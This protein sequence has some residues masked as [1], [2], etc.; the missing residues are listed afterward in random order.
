[1]KDNKKSHGLGG[2]FGASSNVDSTFLATV[3]SILEKNDVPQLMSL[4]E[5]ASLSKLLSNWSYFASINDHSQFIDLSVKL[6]KITNLFLQDSFALVRPQIIEFYKEILQK[7]VKVIYRALNNNKPSLT[8]PNLR[9][10]SNIVKF[11]GSI[12]HEFLNS[13]DF[14][15]SILPNLLV[16]TKTELENKTTK[17]HLSIR[18]NFI[19]FWLTLAASVPHYHRSD[20]MTNNHKIVNNLWKFLYI[21]SAS[22]IKFIVEFL[23]L[24]ILQEV[25]FKRAMKCKILNENFMYKIQSVFSTF[26]SESWFIEFLEKLATDSKSGLVYPHDSLFTGSNTGVPVH[27]N[28]KTF[29]I[30]NKVIYTL[31]TTLK[32]AESHPELSF[33]VKILE[34]NQ[35]L[36]APYM[37]WMVQH[38]GGYHDP[39]LTSWW[40]AHTLLYSNILQLPLPHDIFSTHDASKINIRLVSENIALAPLNKAALQKCLES[41]TKPII[42]QFALQ[43]IMYTIQRLESFL[44][45]L[46]S[47]NQELIEL[48][49]ANLPDIHVIVQV[50]NKVEN[51]SKL[52][53]LTSTM[54]INKYESLYPRQINAGS[55][56]IASMGI[57]SIINKDLSTCSGYDLTLLDLYL[58][59]QSNQQQEQELKW[60]NKGNGSNSLFTSLI[61]LSS[62]SVG[63]SSGKTFSLLEKLTSDKL[64]FS[65][66]LIV[67]PLLALIQS[68]SS[69]IVVDDAVWNLLDEVVSRTVRTPYKYLDLS[70]EKYQDTSL[71]VV[72]LF[73]QFKFMLKQPNLLQNSRWFF[74]LLKFLIVVGESKECLMLLLQDYLLPDI[75]FNTLVDENRLKDILEFTTNNEDKSTFFSY[76][77][78][79][80]SEDLQASINTF[81]KMIPTS[82][83]DFAAM[84]NRLHLAVT[85]STVK[86]VSS[87][88]IELVS[89]V[90]NYLLSTNNSHLIR[91]LES[92]RFWKPLLLQTIDEKLSDSKLLF[93]GLFSEVLQQI[94]NSEVH[95]QELNQFIF[96]LFVETR[97]LSEENQIYL[98]RFS[99]I[100]SD[101]QVKSLLADFGQN[102]LLILTIGQ[103]CIKRSIH[104]SSKY[105]TTLRNLTL[106]NKTSI[107]QSLVQLNLVHFE[108]SELYEEIDSIVA[109]EIDHFLLKSFINSKD[110]RAQSITTYL[111][112]KAEIKDGSLL[113]FI[114]YSVSLSSQSDDNIDA[115]FKKVTSIAAH[116][117]EGGDFEEKTEW[118]QL[119]AIFSKGV[120]FLSSDER[121]KLLVTIFSYIET[122]GYKNSF[123]SEF[124]SLI[125]ACVSHADD[126]IESIAEWIHKSMLYITKKFAESTELSVKFDSFL[127]ELQ[128]IVQKL[129]EISLSI[130]KIV[131]IAIMNTQLEV[132][133]RHPRWISEER[134]LAY[135]NVVIL[136]ASKNIIDYEKLLQIFLNNESSCLNSLP[137][138]SNSK[139]RYMSALVLYNLF[140]VDTS[141]NATFSLL[142]R[143]VLLYLGSTRAEDLLLKAILVKIESHISKSWMVKVSN[144]EF[145]EEMTNNDIELV[146]EDRLIIKSKSDFIVSLSKNF[147]KNSIQNQTPVKILPDVSKVGVA[148]KWEQYQDFYISIEA[149]VD[150]VYSATI[151]D[152]EFLMMLIINN[153][154]LVKFQRADGDEESVGAKFDIKK[155]IDSYILQFIVVQL[156]NP[157]VKNISQI[158]LLG[159]LKSLEETENFKDKSI[160]KVYISNILNTLRVSM[161]HKIPSLIWYIYSSFIPIL[162]NPGH[163]LY[164]KAFRY[165]LGNP[166]LKRGDIPLY[167]GIIL[168]KTDDSE[169]END[170][171]YYKQVLWMIERLIEGT[172]SKDDLDLIK[173]RGVVE[174]IMNLTNSPY[175]TMKI[176]TSIFKYLSVLQGLDQGSDMLITRFGILTSL[177]QISSQLSKAGEK[178]V[179][180]LD[181]QLKIN[182]EQLVLRFGITVGSSKRIREWTA[183]DL[184]SYAKRIHT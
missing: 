85:N 35:E 61:K 1:M 40:V 33:V 50:N 158:L 129:S 84:I 48:V 51:D 99:W 2:S 116:L 8:N 178:N 67:S 179:K 41:S 59:I 80:S 169:T 34:V 46:E 115:F 52:I 114:A 4:L 28:N 150:P 54:I 27:I 87:L 38:G 161:E 20:L 136:T 75:S 88:I 55:A 137:N 12:S 182:I 168:S 109:S 170:E 19:R 72:A 141:K 10:L 171:S 5:S 69:E 93:G 140:Y 66:E 98:S 124:A 24:R 23:D 30:N 7:H 92:P 78:N 43:L 175:L 21:D 159:I 164:E 122:N 142:E 172:N 32:P 103:E 22:T 131:P 107:L 3:S 149:T 31:L 126:I 145:S 64:L 152:A 112:N 160:Y 53:K 106:S 68:F 18:F 105:F 183:D 118:N 111:I 36:V 125:L 173:F 65:T 151:Y 42:V 148:R 29:K 97:I 130:W 96:N 134:Y 123:I 176:K 156:G 128:K 154:E 101:A 37:N 155:L 47:S 166:T 143:I 58:S 57:S 162:S 108:D 13:F 95:N 76:I 102:G 79:N 73:E 146:G 180:L 15:L 138:S 44:S 91:Y 184:S 71:F 133:L 104:I 127:S 132:L 177:E 144:W 49:F 77:I 56:K 90:G 120:K 63:Q 163:F 117:L 74:D 17:E 100:L 110:S 9:I 86:N 135:A 119:L 167:S 39:S 147:I 45:V 121:S 82:S 25:N 113:C 60:W 26:E 16:P 139:S 94:P 14:T 165:V 11:D 6:S 89:K 181:E 81:E 83:L 70:H 174:W 157:I 62:S 153:E